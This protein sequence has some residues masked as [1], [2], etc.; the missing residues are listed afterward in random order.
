MEVGSPA[1]GCPDRFRSPPPPQK[2]VIPRSFQ[3]G[4]IVSKCFFGN[5]SG[6]GW[7]IVKGPWPTEVQGNASDL[8]SHGC[9]YHG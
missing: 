7:E 4:L 3:M 9:P 1:R 8:K 2:I 6:G 5:F